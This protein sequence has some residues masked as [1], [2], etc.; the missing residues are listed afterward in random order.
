MF[1]S[2]ILSS[3]R[4]VKLP[5][6]INYHNLQVLLSE[7]SLNIR[8]SSG[9]TLELEIFSFFFFFFNFENLFLFFIFIYFFFSHSIPLGRPSAPAPSIQ[10]RASNLDWQLISYMIFSLTLSLSVHRMVIWRSGWSGQKQERHSLKYLVVPESKEVLKKWC[11]F[12]S[13]VKS[14]QKYCKSTILQLK[15][16]LKIK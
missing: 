14:T 11:D 8:K 7:R 12:S 4:L 15:K 13:H 10:Y 6:K 1:F 5:R 2:A 3:L 16:F 9:L